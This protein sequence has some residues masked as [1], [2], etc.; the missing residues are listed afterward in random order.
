[1]DGLMTVVLL[2]LL[3]GRSHYQAAHTKR[4]VA[5]A[6]AEAEAAEML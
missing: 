4:D 2:L 3:N 6:A 5:A 1:M